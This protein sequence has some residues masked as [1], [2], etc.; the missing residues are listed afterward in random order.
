MLLRFNNIIVILNIYTAPMSKKGQNLSSIAKLE[1]AGALQ[2][3]V[4]LRQNTKEGEKTQITQIARNTKAA[5][6]TVK[7]TIHYLAQNELVNEEYAKTFPRQHLVWLT[8]KGAT[9]AQHLLE[10]A[11]ALNQPEPQPNKSTA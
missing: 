4:Y 5:S 1:K 9:V 11:A 3:L 10:A 6:E 7:A 2:I 8:P